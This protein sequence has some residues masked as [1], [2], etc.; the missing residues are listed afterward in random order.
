VHF[1]ERKTKEVLA[2]TFVKPG[3]FRQQSESAKCKDHDL[4]VSFHHVSC[5]RVAANVHC[6]ANVGM[7]HEKMIFT[8]P[9]LIFRPA[10]TVRLGCFCQRDQNLS[11]YGQ[12]PKPSQCRWE[13][14]N[15][16]TRSGHILTGAHKISRRRQHGLSRPRLQL[17]VPRALLPPQQQVRFL[18]SIDPV[19]QISA[20]DRGVFKGDILYRKLKL[21]TW[22]PHSPFSRSQHVRRPGGDLD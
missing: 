15:N 7:A 16:L 6:R 11:L 18:S 2:C 13:P 22:T 1:S 19:F 5:G 20:I 21:P 8:H 3:Q 17:S 14:P 10:C 4:A 12:G 9:Q